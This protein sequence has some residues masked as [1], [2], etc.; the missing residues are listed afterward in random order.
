MQFGRSI[1][2]PLCHILA[3][4]TALVPVFMLKVELSDT[5]MRIWIRTDDTHH[6][7]FI[8][9]PNLVG[10]D[11]L[12]GFHL[13]PLTGYLDITNYLCCLAN[14]ICY[15]CDRYPLYALESTTDSCPVISDGVHDRLP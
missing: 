10:T 13:S 1:P 2:P 11:K 14:T 12:I 15:A 9:P 4:N 5:C 6:I 7:D 8:L 3:E